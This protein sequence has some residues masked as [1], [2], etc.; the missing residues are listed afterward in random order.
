MRRR[1]ATGRPAGLGEGR[2][3]RPRRPPEAPGAPGGRTIPIMAQDPRDLDD[4]MLAFWRERHLSTL[5]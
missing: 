2:P 4:A 3:V 5:T 1:A